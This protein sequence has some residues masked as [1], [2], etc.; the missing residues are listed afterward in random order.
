MGFAICQVLG[1]CQ[2]AFNVAPLTV[3]NG[4][5]QVWTACRSV[6]VGGGREGIGGAD[7]A[8][9]CLQRFGVLARVWQPPVASRTR[10]TPFKTKPVPCR[11]AH[12]PSLPPIEPSRCSTLR[13]RKKR[14][15]CSQLVR[16]V[17][18]LSPLNFSNRP[19]SSHFISGPSPF[20]A[21]PVSC[22]SIPFHFPMIVSLF[23]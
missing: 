8:V 1:F 9:G 14:L 13:S 20:F 19:S 2:A 5:G 11:D 6:E 16:S 22:P 15:S 7:L 10:R 12:S 18:L 4:W 3:M 23:V 21:V 17:Y